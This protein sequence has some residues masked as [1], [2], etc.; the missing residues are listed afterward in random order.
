KQFT[1]SDILERTRA[2]GPRRRLVA[3]R[4]DEPR[5][6]ARSGCAILGAAG[7]GIGEITSGTFSPTLERGIGLGY[8]PSAL[9]P[10]D[11]ASAV[12]VRGRVPTPHT[13]RKPLYAKET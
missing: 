12:D 8:V 6:V 7:D 1:G 10:P 4:M 11:T 9:A 2:D 3:V 13:A 5:A